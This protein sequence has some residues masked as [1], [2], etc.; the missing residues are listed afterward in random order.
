MFDVCSV[1]YTILTEYSHLFA[2]IKAID[3]FYNMS[4]FTFSSG[5]SLVY[6]NLAFFYYLTTLNESTLNTMKLSCC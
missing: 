4:D 2:F 1:K 6:L 5:S 3:I